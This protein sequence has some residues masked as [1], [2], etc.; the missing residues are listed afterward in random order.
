MTNQELIK[1]LLTAFSAA[2]ITQSFVLLIAWYRYKKDLMTKKKLIDTDLENQLA[3]LK[4]LKKHYEELLIKFQKRDLES[5]AGNVFE[6]LFLDIYEAIEKPDL[7]RIYKKKIIDLVDIYKVIE[8]LKSK[9]P[10]QIYVVYVDDWQEHRESDEHKKHNNENCPFHL[11]TLDTAE[12]Q[13]KHNLESLI[14][15]ENQIDR[16][17]CFEMSWF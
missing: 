15:V 4:K 16:I 5:Y 10:Y 7:Y 9:T 14:S 12:G 2:I 3:I 13:I 8:F 11:S 17:M 6:D 1:I